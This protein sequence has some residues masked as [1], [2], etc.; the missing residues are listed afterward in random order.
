MNFAGSSTRSDKI[1]GVR[2]SQKHAAVGHR[3]RGQVCGD[4]LDQGTIK[5]ITAREHYMMTG[6]PPADPVGCGAFVS[7]IRAGASAT[8]AASVPRPA[9]LL[10]AYF[11]AG[12]DVAL[13]RPNFLGEQ[14]APFVVERERTAKT[15][16][17]DVA[18]PRE[19]SE[20]RFEGRKD[21]RE[22]VDRMVRSTMRRAADPGGTSIGFMRGG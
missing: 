14:F 15:S 9:R 3:F 13:G 11:F 20:G 7:F 5:G 19:V 21:L 22:V 1:R 12:A 4:S 2:D 8:A 10:H 18:I 6:A 16:R 17:G